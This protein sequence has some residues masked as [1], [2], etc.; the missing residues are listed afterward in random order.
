MEKFIIGR[1]DKED[2][3][4][5]ERRARRGEVYVVH[6]VKHRTLKDYR[7]KPKHGGK[8]NLKNYDEFDD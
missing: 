3:M 4:K 8:I 5:A 1:I 2:R 7:R 6:H